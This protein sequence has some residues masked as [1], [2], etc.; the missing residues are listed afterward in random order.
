M[1]VVHGA[2]RALSRARKGESVAHLAATLNELLRKESSHE[3]VTLFWGLYNSTTHD[4]TY[5]NAGHLPPL[6]VV[7]SGEVR[8]LETG[9]PVLGLLAGALYRDEHITL[10]GEELFVAYSDG[11]IEA[12]SPEGQ[13]FGESRVLSGIRAS[14]GK[15]PTEVLRHIIREAM[16]FVESGEFHDDLTLLVVKLKQNPSAG[17]DRTD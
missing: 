1:G 5:V 12:M 14:I 15:S 8:R 9:G 3:F 11:L 6:L 10:D 17:D 2:V 13:E 4:L 16:K 7:R